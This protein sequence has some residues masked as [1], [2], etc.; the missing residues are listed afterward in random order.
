[1]TKIP[2]AVAI[3]LAAGAASFKIM[4]KQRGHFLEGRAC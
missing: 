1:M 4:W 2:K 3:L